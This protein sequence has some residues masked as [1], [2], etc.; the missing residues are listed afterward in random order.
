M[1]NVAGSTPVAR[2]KRPQPSIDCQRR[3]A[4]KAIDPESG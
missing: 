1:L 3:A 4:M 2:S